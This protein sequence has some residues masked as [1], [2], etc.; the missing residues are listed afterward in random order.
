M[1]F[2]ENHEYN[3]IYLFL[4]LQN[5]ASDENTCLGFKI[6]VM[7]GKGSH[8]PKQLKLRYKKRLVLLPSGKTMKL[9]L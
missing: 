4:Y 6:K 2:I 3:R 5:T 1:M 9:E 7:W 8:F